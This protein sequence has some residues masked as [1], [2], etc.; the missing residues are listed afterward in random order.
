MKV[1]YIALWTKIVKKICATHNILKDIPRWTL[2]GRSQASNTRLW[3]YT[4]FLHT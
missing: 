1:A 3:I 2:D 4:N